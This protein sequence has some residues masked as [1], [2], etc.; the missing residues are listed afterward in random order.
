MS[1]NP[2]SLASLTQHKNK[3]AV[4]NAD[5]KKCRER[6]RH[7]PFSS[8]TMQ[9]HGSA[10]AAFGSKW[11][12]STDHNRIDVLLQPTRCLDELVS[13]L[14]KGFVTPS[15]VITLFIHDTLGFEGHSTA[16]CV[17][18]IWHLLSNKSWRND[19]FSGLHQHQPR[20]VMWWR[21]D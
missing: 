2:H 14:K 9:A 21:Q 10:T 17:S 19:W 6:L 20:H 15:Q 16:D 18:S 7:D 12:S 11:W 1:Q 13:S 8:K 4:N 5:Y 3:N